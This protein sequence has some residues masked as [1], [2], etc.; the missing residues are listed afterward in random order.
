MKFPPLVSKDGI[1]VTAFEDGSVSLSETMCS[2]LQSETG[3]Y[4]ARI[5]R[6]STTDLEWEKIY[7]EE[8]RG[9]AS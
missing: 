2:R 7:Y 4:F 5:R 1:L 3:R 8:V 6:K 9:K